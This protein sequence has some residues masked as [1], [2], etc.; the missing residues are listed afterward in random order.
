[1]ER[2]AAGVTFMQG[3]FDSSIVLVAQSKGQAEPD[4]GARMA[5]WMG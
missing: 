3:F 4:F 1:M 2:R 5:A